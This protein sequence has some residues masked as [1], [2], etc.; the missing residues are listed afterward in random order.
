MIIKYDHISFVEADELSETE[1]GE[2]GLGSTGV[3]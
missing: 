2:G 3:K 1:R